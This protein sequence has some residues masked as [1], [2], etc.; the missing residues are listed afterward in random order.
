MG[1]TPL[2]AI[3]RKCLDC[4]CG[5]SSEVK[6]C[7]LINAPSGRI[8]SGG[9]RTGSGSQHPHS[10]KPLKMAVCRLSPWTKWAFRENNAE[11]NI[12]TPPHKIFLIGVAEERIFEYELPAENLQHRQQFH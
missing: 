9:I 8:G 4:C 11:G 5:S 3:R 2:N 1:T 7:T 12:N 10:L 6:L